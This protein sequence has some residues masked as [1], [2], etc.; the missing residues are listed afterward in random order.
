VDAPPTASTEEPATPRVGRGQPPAMS[1]V[2]HR[3]AWV[4]VGLAVV[5]SGL[6]I[7]WRAEF[8]Q[9]LPDAGACLVLSTERCA[10]KQIAH[11]SMG[12]QPYTP[13]W[14]WLPALFGIACGIVVACT[15]PQR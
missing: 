13:E 8:Y 3:L 7:N 5:F 11:L 6:A 14:F 12:Y 2:L 1:T 9:D 15:R 4:G 10:I